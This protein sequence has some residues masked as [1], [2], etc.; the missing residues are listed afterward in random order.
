MSKVYPEIE[1]AVSEKHERLGE[2]LRQTLA[3]A[4]EI[5][6]DKGRHLPGECIILRRMSNSDPAGAHHPGPHRQSIRRSLLER[7]K[8]LNLNDSEDSLSPSP[9]P[10]HASSV[11]EPFSPGSVASQS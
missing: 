6:E 1:D 2:L 10:S 4:G 11:Q 8:A 5:A 3:L 9:S 7:R